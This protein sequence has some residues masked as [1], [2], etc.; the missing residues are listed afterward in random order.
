MPGDV[1]DS[2]G[3]E[4]PQGDSASVTG[5]APR[6]PLRRGACLPA[7]RSPAGVFPHPTPTHAPELRRRS[8]LRALMALSHMPWRLY[9]AYAEDL[10]AP[11]PI[12]EYGYTDIGYFGT[13]CRCT[14]SSR[15]HTTANLGDAEV[16][17]CSFACDTEPFCATKTRAARYTAEFF[18]WRRIAARPSATRYGQWSGGSQ[19]LPLR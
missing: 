10:K 16:P 7:T 9:A 19:P 6:P 18:T 11:I 15:R 4:P 17:S 1:P 3:R 5:I 2:A 8:P 13:R 12:P 14:R